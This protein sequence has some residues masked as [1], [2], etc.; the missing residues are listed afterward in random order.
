MVDP[1]EFPPGWSA[2]TTDGTPARR[3]FTMGTMGSRFT[4]GGAGGTPVAA[5]PEVLAGGVAAIHAWVEQL[6]LD[7]MCW[8]DAFV[9]LEGHR[10]DPCHVELKRD[11]PC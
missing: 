10:L 6:V 8:G 4:T 11:D 2:W 3:V 5:P 7:A 1:A 9:D